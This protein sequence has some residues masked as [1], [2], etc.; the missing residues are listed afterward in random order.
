[1]TTEFNRYVEC[2]LMPV[3]SDEDPRAE[4]SLALLMGAAIPPR[5]IIAKS[6]AGEGI[7]EGECRP[8]VRQADHFFRGNADHCR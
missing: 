6:L 8:R 4:A 5:Q 7:E 2:C 1:M 3:P